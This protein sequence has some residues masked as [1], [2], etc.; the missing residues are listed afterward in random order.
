MPAYT[1]RCPAGHLIEH[2]QSIH[3]P[4]PA[5]IACPVVIVSTD[6]ASELHCASHASRVIDAPAAV[7]F[8]GPGFYSTDVR[9]SQQRRRR[10]NPGDDLLRQH[11]PA[12][13][14]IARSL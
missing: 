12:A 7:H 4:L 6:D 2:V 10:P 14:A 11:D 5:T 9:G 8:K 3:D 1:Y 13:A